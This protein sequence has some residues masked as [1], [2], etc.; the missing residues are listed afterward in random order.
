MTKEPKAVKKLLY[1]KKRLITFR[2][3]KIIQI[4][5]QSNVSVELLLPPRKH[6]FLDFMN[7]HILYF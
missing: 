2:K 1:I 4:E 3:Q 7:E 5:S 6:K